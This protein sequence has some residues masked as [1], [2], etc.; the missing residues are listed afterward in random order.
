MTAG[1]KER[2]AAEGECPSGGFEEKLKALNRYHRLH[3]PPYE[4]LCRGL[5]EEMPVLPAAVF[6]SVDLY[7]TE[8]KNLIGQLSS[9]GSSGQKRSRIWLDA[10]TARAQQMA[11][12]QIVSGVLGTER[13]PMLIVDSPDLL[14]HG[15]SFSAREAGILGFS[16]MASKRIYALHAD[17]TLNWENIRKYEQLVKG[18]K[19]LIFGFTFLLWKYFCQPLLEAD[20][21]PDLSDCLVIHGGGWKKMQDRAVSPE[22]FRNGIR[23]ACG[24]AEIYD[25][26]GM[27]EQTGSIFLACGQGH[28]H[29]NP[30]ARI[31]VVDP[32][33]GRECPK[34]TPGV[35]VSQSLLPGSYPGH[36]ILTEDL[37]VVLGVDDCPCGKPG[38]YF[39]VL[40]RMKQA[41]IRGCSDTFAESEDGRQKDGSEEPKDG[42]QADSTAKSE[43]RMQEDG[44]AKPESGS[45]GRQKDGITV[46]AGTFPPLRKIRRVGD[47]KTAVFLGTLSDRIL[48]D[49]A[50]RRQPDVYAFG[51]WCRPGHV[52]EMLRESDGSRQ[53]KG[54]ILHIAPSNMPV[55]YAYSWAAALLAGNGSIVRIPS[56]THPET[57]LLCRKI[58]EVFE[59]P[60]FREFQQSNCLIRFDRNDRILEGLTDLCQGRMLW[61]STAVTE[62]LSGIRGTGSGHPADLLFPGKYSISLLDAE[63]MSCLSGEEL[64]QYAVRFCADT[65]PADQNACS[66][67]KLL[68][69]KTGTLS[70]GEADR[71]R[72]KWWGLVCRYASEYPMDAGKMMEKYRNLS[73]AYLRETGLKPVKRR[74]RQVWTVEVQELPERLSCLEGSLGLFF[75]TEVQRT[76]ELFPYLT[77]EIQTVTVAEI[78]AEEFWKQI[79]KA[80]CAGVDRV[81]PMGEALQFLLYWDRKDLLRLLSEPGR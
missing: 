30:Y 36:N 49:P 10:E 79:R 42:M 9:S 46:L 40:G 15:A 64:E 33:T 2:Q 26:Y 19:G 62:H 39:Q 38:K 53:G 28:L 18:K 47:R 23:N 32:M 72:Q 81:V 54:I 14:K 48:S 77:G 43:E 41:E 4:R 1:G 16:L 59:L 65:Y 5:E 20:R 80:G 35:I 8:Q 68:F 75:E 22:A 74:L 7:S 58:K 24:C 61:G 44:C 34:G 52:R 70:A 69:W 78:D 45:A 67:P 13:V 27:A 37:G 55:M 25:Y 6:K 31:R 12:Y 66:S 11:L 57:E 50:C 73:L 21:K 60:E 17:N 29:E 3:C 71:L 76:E 63:R 51:F 56:K